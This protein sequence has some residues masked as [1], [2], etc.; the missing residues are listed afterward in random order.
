MSSRAR[1]RHQRSNGSVGKKILLGLGVVLVVIGIA[2]GAAAGW[3]YDMWDDAGT[4]ES[5]KE[6]DEGA[7]SKVYAADGSLLG[8][9]DANIIREPVGL[10]TIPKLL[11]QA[12]IA[13]EDENFYK[14]DGVDFSAIIRA[15]VENVEAGEIEQGASTIT[16]QLVRNLYIKE[17][18][19]TLE[20]K[21]TEAKWSMEFE[22][23]YTK[24]EI[25]E[26]YLNTAT[27]GTNSGD[28]AVG[29]EAASQVYFNKPIDEINIGE[30]ALLAGLPQAPSQYNPFT[31]SDAATKRRNLVLD[32]MLDQGYIRASE[33]AKWSKAGLGLDRGLRYDQ[34]R[35]RY[36][37]DYVQQELIDRYGTN[38]AR[39]GGL[40]V[41]T[42]LLPNLQDSAETAIRNNP[43]PTGAAAAL[44]STDVDTGEIKAM[45][46]S[47]NYD[48]SKFNLAAQGRRQP[49]SSYKPFA[50]AAAVE[51]GI[52][53]DTTSYPAPQ[54]ITL[55]EYPGG[56]ATWD[57]SGGA[58]KSSTLRNATANSINTVFAQLV[59][60]IG[61]EAMNDAAHRM[62]IT[63]PTLDVPAEVLGTASV[64]VL[65][66]SNAFATFAN[67]GVH[68]DPTAINRVEFPN[69]DVEELDP[70][71]G[72]RAFSDGVAY[73]VADVMKGAL[74]Y[75]TAAGLGIGCPASG[76][77]GTTEGQAD[78]WFVGYTPHVSTAVWM[79]SPN[80]RTPM[81]GYGGTLAAPIWQD[82]MTVAATEPC[83]DFPEPQDPVSLSSGSS[84]SLSDSDV[85][86]SSDTTTTTPGITD[87]DGDGFDD[88]AY[89]PGTGDM[90]VPP[91]D[92]GDTGGGAPGGNPG[93]G[94]GLAP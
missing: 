17:P 26:K 63:S 56:P 18:E 33:H 78:V 35:Y 70:S 32:A 31:S 58:G 69:G 4:F 88:E 54:T 66:M 24:D 52:D 62:G 10:K 5:E 1:K 72:K 20:R 21:L 89:L 34:F 82:Y 28:T 3:V 73:T 93:A 37:F 41:H 29:V 16:Q 90:D 42:T 75:G 11:Q 12:T 64:S 53:P 71:N 57:V 76:K 91:V 8:I 68:H 61:P 30:A 19:D 49:G 7:N 6:I 44:V 25:L 65:E 55:P 39:V 40:E 2:A 87:A 83:D 45:A 86:D 23:E 9:I 51:Q 14:H 92:D 84:S 27:Y 38:T 43:I 15:T 36:F 67:G 80:D 13:I 46:S 22:E 85:I 81:P 47:T 94:G 48:D 60:D 77:T 74:E 50:L 59:V 79:G